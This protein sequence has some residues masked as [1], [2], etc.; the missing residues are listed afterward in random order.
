MLFVFTSL[1]RIANQMACDAVKVEELHL[2][3]Q[4]EVSENNKEVNQKC[5]TRFA[6]LIEMLTFV[7]ILVF[8][9]NGE[10]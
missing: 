9:V 8:F 3:K 10:G 5:E 1:T 2:A 4:N 6:F 7:S